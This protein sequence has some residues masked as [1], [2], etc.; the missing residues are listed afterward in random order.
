M[1]LT[2]MWMEMTLWSMGNHSILG[3]K[4]GKPT[5]TKVAGASKTSSYSWSQSQLVGVG[6]VPEDSEPLCPSATLG[7]LSLTTMP[8]TRRLMS[9]HAQEKSLVKPRRE[10]HSGVQ[11]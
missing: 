5:V 7:L 1:M 11:S 2:W 9:S 6:G 3:V 4:W 10:R 8:D